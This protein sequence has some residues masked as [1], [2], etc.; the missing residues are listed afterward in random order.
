M[1]RLTDGQRDRLEK[2]K[3]LR[4]ERLA[5]KGELARGER[6]FNSETKVEFA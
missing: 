1:I 4:D 2:V 5:S 6:V 3:S